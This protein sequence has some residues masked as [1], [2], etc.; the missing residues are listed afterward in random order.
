[1]ETEFRVCDAVDKHVVVVVEVVFGLDF[2]LWV[3]D[4]DGDWCA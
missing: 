4:V 1:M 3:I 2:A